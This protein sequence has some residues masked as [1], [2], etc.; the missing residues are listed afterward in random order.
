MKVLSPQVLSFYVRT[1]RDQLSLEMFGSREMTSD[2]T[3]GI[4]LDGL[5]HPCAIESVS[6]HFYPPS[7]RSTCIFL[8]LSRTDFRLV[9]CNMLDGS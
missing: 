1:C 4:L 3:G 7:Y 2:E 6:R 8:S 9:G 5:C